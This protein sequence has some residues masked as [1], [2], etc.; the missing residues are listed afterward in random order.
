MDQFDLN[1]SNLMENSVGLKRVKYIH[2]DKLFTY[3]RLAEYSDA[4][5]DPAT[6]R[7]RFGPM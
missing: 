2:S 1:V 3:F 4:Q 6:D 7:S 5:T